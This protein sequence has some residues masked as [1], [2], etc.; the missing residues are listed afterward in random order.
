MKISSKPGRLTWG[1][2]AMQNRLGLAWRIDSIVSMAMGIRLFHLISDIII[3]VF[4]GERKKMEPQ[5]VI[6]Y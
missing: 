3:K 1:R 4:G 6:S 5:P 2:P